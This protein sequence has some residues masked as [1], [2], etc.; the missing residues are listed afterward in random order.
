MARRVVSFRRIALI[1]LT[2]KIQRN[3][4][5]KQLKAT[6]KEADTLA[7]WEGSSWAKKLAAKNKS[8]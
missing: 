2:V 5:A 6:W 8:I 4:H 3:A 7:Q 1:D